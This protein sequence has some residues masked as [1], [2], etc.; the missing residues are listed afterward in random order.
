MIADGNFYLERLTRYH[1][2]SSLPDLFL[3]DYG[4]ADTNFVEYREKSDGKS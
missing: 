3:P 1:R 4:L 2:H